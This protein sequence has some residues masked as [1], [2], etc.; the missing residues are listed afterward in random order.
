MTIAIFLSITPA[1]ASPCIDG[2]SVSDAD[3]WATHSCWWDFVL[4]QYKAYRMSDGDWGPSAWGFRDACNSGLPY[5]KAVN[6]SYL[7]TYGLNE[8]AWQWHGTIDYRRAAEA[9]SSVNHD[10]MHYIPNSGRAWLARPRGRPYSD[11]LSAVRSNRD[12][13]GAFHARRRLCA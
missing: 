5:P 2:P 6:A 9:W 7:L 12:H 11:E 1:K 3:L 13:R 10:Q 8:S 4:W